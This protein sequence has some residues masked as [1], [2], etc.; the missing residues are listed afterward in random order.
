MLLYCSLKTGVGQEFYTGA[1]CAK[2]INSI[3]NNTEHYFNLAY[4]K[5]DY[6]L[7]LMYVVCVVDSKERSHG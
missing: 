4:I 2:K 7:F 3:N 1:G 5:D 6:I